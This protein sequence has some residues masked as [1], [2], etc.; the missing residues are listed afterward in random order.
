MKA[1]CSSKGIHRRLC[2]LCSW[3]PTVFSSMSGDKEAADVHSCL[4]LWHWISDCHLTTEGERSSHNLQDALGWNIPASAHHFRSTCWKACSG[5]TSIGSLE[6]AL[7][8]LKRLRQRKSLQ[9]QPRLS[10]RTVSGDNRNS[11][12]RSFLWLPHYKLIK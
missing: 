10:C 2:S 5:G 4:S 1:F 7:P 12:Q 6:D 8:K 3:N 11:K 9:S